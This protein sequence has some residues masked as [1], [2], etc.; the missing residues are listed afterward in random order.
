MADPQCCWVGRRHC[1]LSGSQMGERQSSL[2]LGKR[3]ALLNTFCWESLVSG[4]IKPLVWLVAMSSRTRGSKAVFSCF[5]VAS[6]KKANAILNLGNIVHLF[7]QFL[8]CSATLS[9]YSDRWYSF[10]LVV[11]IMYHLAEDGGRLAQVRTY[12]WAPCPCLRFIHREEG[13][14][15]EC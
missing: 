4:S 1:V 15:R 6:C 8:P 12:H 9:S 2:F 7:L 14:K 10:P 3:V 11:V 5:L 13:V